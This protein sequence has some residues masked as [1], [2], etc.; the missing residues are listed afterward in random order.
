DLTLLRENLKRTPT[1][2]LLKNSQGIRLLRALDAARE[3]GR[4]TMSKRKRTPPDLD[5]EALLH[6]LKVSGV[7]YVLVG[8][9][10]MRLQGSAHITDDCD[11][12]YARPS[13][14]LQAVAS[15]FASLHPYLRG[16]PPGLPFHFDA[17]TIRA[18]LNFTLTT[19][20]GDVDLLG[21]VS[22]IG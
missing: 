8:G 6:Q 3:E 19:D 5:I 15:A 2:R 9:L 4:L 22:G 1:E 10:A 18:G 21:E 14:N 16:A 20:L 11:I 17:V 12:C 13:R 7:Q